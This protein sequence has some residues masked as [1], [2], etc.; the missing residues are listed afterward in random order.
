MADIQCFWE[1]G[2]SLYGGGGG[3]GGLDNQLETMLYCY[4][5]L[6]L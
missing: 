3:G 5:I 2:K 6:P 4:I 1:G